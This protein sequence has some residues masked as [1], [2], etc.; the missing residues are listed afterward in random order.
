MHISEL[1]GLQV[2]AVCFVRDYIE[3]C[4]D[5][6]VVR[7]IHRYAMRDSAIVSSNESNGWRDHLCTLLGK[8]VTAVELSDQK[9]CKIYFDS[10]AILDIDLLHKERF[11]GE[12]MHFFSG[13]LE[14]LQVW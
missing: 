4:F 11:S 13:P 10:C 12:A 9:Y 7:I 1:Q 8:I 14:P 6:P 5:G 3:I 2:S